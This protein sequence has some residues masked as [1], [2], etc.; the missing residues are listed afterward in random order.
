MCDS[1]SLL[2]IPTKGLSFTWSSR[3]SEVRLD[4]AL[5]NLDW[6]ESWASME[7]STLT[8]AASDHCPILLSCSRLNSVVKLPFRFQ[9]MW[10]QVPDFLGLVR[11][12][13]ASF[14]FH[15]YPQFVLASKLRALK[16]VLKEWNR[17][18]VGD[19]HSR[20]AAS[21]ATLDVVQSEISI[22]G[23]YVERFSHQEAAHA[24]FLAD[25]SLQS[26]LLRD[27]SRVRQLRLLI[28]STVYCTLLS[29]LS[30]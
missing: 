25:L 16:Q 14:Q 24:K 22:L 13:W 5:G 18:Q 10:L 11:D 3:R 27:K 23:P 1:C 2:D 29:F 12:S 28:I 7:C 30:V 4:R 8:K 17:L 26:T 21:R 9:S 15:G 6:F 20:V 19:V